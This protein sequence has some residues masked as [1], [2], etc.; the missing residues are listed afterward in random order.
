[1]RLIDR[2]IQDDI[3]NGTSYTKE[4]AIYHLQKELAELK[5]K[6][7]WHK[8]ESVDDLPSEDFKQWLWRHKSSGNYFVGY[9]F[10]GELSL[11]DIDYRKPFKQFDAYCEIPRFE[12]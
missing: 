6:Y 8:I 10:Q 4:G 3:D 9:V 7:T 2:M 5:A 12:E 1:M 11:N